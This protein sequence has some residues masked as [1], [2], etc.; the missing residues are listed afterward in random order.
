MF[1]AGPGFE[2]EHVLAARIGS[3]TDG[4]AFRRMLGERLR[5]VPGVVS[6][7]F[8]EFMPMERED[9]VDVRVAGQAAGTGRVVAM[10][11]VSTNFFE[12][13]GIPIVRGR[14][15]DEG[16]SATDRVGSVVIVSENFAR[17]FWPAE[18]PVE[19]VIEAPERLRVIGVSRNSRSA[20]YGEQDR[21]QLFRLE[22]RKG[23]S[24]S[25]LVR[26]Q[27]NY[28]EVAR[29]IAE[30]LHNS[31]GVENSEPE[32]LKR[33]MDRD[34]SD[35]WAIAEM[36][37]FLGIAAI[38]LAVIGTY[39][40]AAFAVSHRTKEFGI[41]MAL[42]AMR[43]QIIHLVVRSG[44]KPICGGLFLGVCLTLGA[45]H[46]LAKLMKNAYF[47]LDMH[48]PLVYLVVCLL[49]ILAATAATLIPA[50]RSTGTDP[51]HALREE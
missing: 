42:G 23:R 24:G 51:V 20:R 19:K 25:L 16:D 8:A 4:W 21:P 10:N 44:A 26:F 6:V 15:F 22:N 32:T 7:C 30:V 18:D 29:G 12:T 38:V 2:I 17:E 33:I 13:L 34:I 41:R 46:G 50:L 39:G 35:F 1:A 28:R 11:S 36:V 49:L 9:S 3:T 47:V 27:G 14:A 40:V 5:G 31:K 43:A 48:D 37:L 45:S